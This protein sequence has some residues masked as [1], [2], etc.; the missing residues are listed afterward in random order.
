MTRHCNGTMVMKYWGQVNLGDAVLRGLFSRWIDQYIGLDGHGSTPTSRRGASTHGGGGHG[1]GNGGGGARH[2][3]NGSSYSSG[4]SDSED[5]D[6]GRESDSESRSASPGSGLSSQASEGAG[7]GTSGGGGVRPAGRGGSIRSNNVLDSDFASG[8][9]GGGGS[10]RAIGDETVLWVTETDLGGNGG[11]QRTMLQKR[12]GE[13]NGR[14]VR[15]VPAC[16]G[17]G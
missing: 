11:M 3:D 17:C 6:H 16:R 9:G 8:G 14:E 12:V 10:G 15:R 1:N 5:S 2:A 13:F 7:S 4:D